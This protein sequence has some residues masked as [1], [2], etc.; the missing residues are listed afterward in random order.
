MRQISS[1]T[2]S[3][4][5]KELSPV[6]GP[7]S[8]VKKAFRVLKAT[9]GITTNNEQLLPKL[10][11]SASFESLLT[12]FHTIEPIEYRDEGLDFYVTMT[13][14]PGKPIEIHVSDGEI[15]LTGSI[16]QAT[17]QVSDLRYTVFGNEG[18]LFR[19]ILMMLEKKHGIYSLHACSLYNEQAN[20]LYIAAGTSGSGKS[21]LLIKGLELGLKLFS[22]EMT[23]F[24]LDHGPIFYKGAV[25]DNVRIGNLKYSYPF[26][27]ERLKGQLPETD[28]EWGRKVAV[29]LGEMQAASDTIHSPKITLILPRVE[30]GRHKNFTSHMKDKRLTHKALFDNISEKIASNVLLY[31][32][33]PSGGLDSPALMRGR[34]Q[35][36]DGLLDHVDRTVKVVAGSENCWEGLMG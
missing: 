10:F 21:C 35:A 31:D 13:D 33:I 30:E 34:C 2:A 14:I 19:Y 9:F 22:A 25:V 3:A 8:A 4:S 36:I 5:H 18:L 32:S 28:D 26:L 1:H 27:L 23:H 20:H 11:F 24:Y 15:H 29:D 12:D 17:E 16:F 7:H 6:T